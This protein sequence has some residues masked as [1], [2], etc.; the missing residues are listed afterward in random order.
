MRRFT[1]RLIWR[2]GQANARRSGFSLTRIVHI[3]RVRLK[4]DL[5]DVMLVLLGSAAVLQYMVCSMFTS[6][7]NRKPR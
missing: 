2:Y 5:H 7:A 4:P 6:Q 1:V 3:D